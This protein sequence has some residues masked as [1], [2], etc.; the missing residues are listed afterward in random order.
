MRCPQCGHFKT[1]VIDT[2]HDMHGGI[3]RRR[4]CEKCTHRFSTYERAVMTTP[5]IVKR[6]NMREGFDREKL[7]EGIRIAC[8]KRPIPAAEIERLVGEI[9]AHLQQM[10]KLE[11]P[12]SVIGD[13]VIEGLKQLDLIAYIRYAIVY[14]PLDNLNDIRDEINRLLKGS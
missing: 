6:D 3:R 1:R 13:M 9:E 7:L 11:V 10:N 12:S 8:A 14:L 2:T 4:E 5:M